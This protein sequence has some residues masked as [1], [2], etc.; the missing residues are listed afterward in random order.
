MYTLYSRKDY[1]PKYL[2]TLYSNDYAFL[3]ETTSRERHLTIGQHFGTISSLKHEMLLITVKNISECMSDRVC[4]TLNYHP[5]PTNEYP[6]LHKRLT[7]H[8]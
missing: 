8:Y 1:H 7:A 4:R 6:K 3:K 2:L 5:L